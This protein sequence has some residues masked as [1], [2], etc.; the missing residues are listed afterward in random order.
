MQC[1]GQGETELLRLPLATEAMGAD[2]AVVEGLGLNAETLEGTTLRIPGERALQR[3]VQLPRAVAENLSQVLQ[4]EMDRLTPFR[5]ED[6]YY[7][8]RI[9]DERASQ[10]RIGVQ[11][12]LVPRAYLDPLLAKVEQLGF[13]PEVIDLAPPSE[14]GMGP[15]ERSPINLLPEGRA[16]R[17]GTPG[18]RRNL[19]LA[20]LTAVL[21]VAALAIPLWQMHQAAQSLE[22]EVQAARKEALQTTALVDQLDSGVAQLRFLLEKKLSTPSVIDVLDEM[23]RTLP[24][25]T[26]LTSFQ[27]D[28][29][30]IT[31]QGESE[32]A[33]DLIARIEDSPR[34]EKA[35]FLSS[36]THNQYSKTDRFQIGTETVG[37]GL[38]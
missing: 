31:I 23:T 20:G 27:M 25:G 16:T 12:T 11:L 30:K 26:W 2:Q 17:K 33:S 5:S 9:L 8:F 37:G 38:K 24:D 15:C 6:V 19:A 22:Q 7:D 1:Q 35:R 36:V 3:V 4:F 14:Q 13:R 32:V 28:G 21:L 18:L 29:D 34:F 10:A